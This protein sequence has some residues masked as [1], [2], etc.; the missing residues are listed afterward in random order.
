MTTE[1][2]YIQKDDFAGYKPRFVAKLCYEI[3]R[4]GFKQLG[5]RLSKVSPIRNAINRFDITF[6]LTLARLGYL[7]QTKEHL[8]HQICIGSITTIIEA[9]NKTLQSKVASLQDRNIE[10]FAKANPRVLLLFIHNFMKEA[11]DVLI[12]DMILKGKDQL[13]IKTFR[14]KMSE[15]TH[16]IRD[17]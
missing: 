7:G 17:L 4:H 6:R 12:K 13:T 3:C 14:L 1:T 10:D 16:I 11:Y 5:K 2:I 15:F 8:V 9:R